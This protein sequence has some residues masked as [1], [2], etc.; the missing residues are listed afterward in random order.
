MNWD[1]TATAPFQLPGINNN[2][3][4][5]TV[6]T[7]SPSNGSTDNVYTAPNT[8]INHPSLFNA[9]EWGTG[10]APGQIYAPSDLPR[11]GTRYA[12]QPNTFFVSTASSTTESC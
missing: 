1:G 10:T 6:P 2:N 9:A 3:F 5:Q 11:L 12:D 4:L 7:F 8:P